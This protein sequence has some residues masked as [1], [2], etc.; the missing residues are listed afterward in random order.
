M[1]TY[2]LYFKIAEEQSFQNIS[3]YDPTVPKIPNG[4]YYFKSS[5]IPIFD[6]KNNLDIGDLILISNIYIQNTGEK[7]VNHKFIMYFKGEICPPGVLECSYNF[8]SDNSQYLFPIDEEFLLSNIASQGDY[9]GINT[10]I[11]CFINGDQIVDIKLI[12]E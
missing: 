4:V 10:K 12:I 9:I 6:K 2:N 5:Y 8:T 7:F 1:T 11:Y 3:N